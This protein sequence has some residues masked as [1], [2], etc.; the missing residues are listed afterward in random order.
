MKIIKRSSM[1]SATSSIYVLCQHGQYVD[2]DKLSTYEVSFPF[3]RLIQ[4]SRPHECL[5][6]P[7]FLNENTIGQRTDYLI[8][9]AS[10]VSRAN[11]TIHV[12]PLLFSLNYKVECPEIQKYS[13]VWEIIIDTATG[14]TKSIEHIMNGIEWSNILDK[15]KQATYSTLF[16]ALMVILTER[17]INPVNVS[18][19]LWT[20]QKL[21]DYA[22][23]QIQGGK[24]IS[25]HVHVMPQIQQT[26]E[27]FQLDADTTMM[28]PQVSQ[29]QFDHPLNELVVPIVPIRWSGMSIIHFLTHL[30]IN[31]C[32]SRISVMHT[33]GQS[34]FNICAF[35]DACLVESRCPATKYCVVRQ[36]LGGPALYNIVTNLPIGQATVVTLYGPDVDLTSGQTI[37]IYK[38]LDSI[39]HVVIP[40]TGEH[41]LF[42]VDDFLSQFRRYDYID[43]IYISRATIDDDNRNVENLDGFTHKNNILEYVHITYGGKRRT[44]RRRKQLNNI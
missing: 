26:P 40:S 43:V 33:R 3:S 13:G 14:V 8:Y 16:D 11:G 9:G 27:M 19:G 30:N 10:S 35:I 28:A 31:E 6:T 42:L 37:C 5:S 22:I 7:L 1:A 15:E 24:I 36:W 29:L 17:G 21:S 20:C 4:Y 25:P 12:P 38:K 23:Q 34:I 18:V 41:K 39:P 44:R 32:R 2:E